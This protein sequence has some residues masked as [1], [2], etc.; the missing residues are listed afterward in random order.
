MLLVIVGL[1]LFLLLLFWLAWSYSRGKFKSSGDDPS[2]KP[3]R[4]PHALRMKPL[5]HGIYH[6]HDERR[7][8]RQKDPPPER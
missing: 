2:G 7:K 5:G 1:P 3:H 6:A 8:A 4:L